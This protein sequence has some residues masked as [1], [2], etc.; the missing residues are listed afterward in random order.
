VPDRYPANL[1]RLAA[2]MRELNARLR[3]AGLSDYEARQLPVQ[4]DP[5]ARGQ[6]ELSTWMTD[7]GAFDVLAGLE[8]AH[9]RVVP[10]EELAQRA[11]LGRRSARS[12]ARR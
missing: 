3:V 1:Q 9:G 6:L 11:N 12:P 4:V 5:N 10:Y 7:A 8:D 2:A